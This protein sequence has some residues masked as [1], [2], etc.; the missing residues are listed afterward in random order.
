MMK[1]KFKNFVR[2][3]F[4]YLYFRLVRLLDLL[5]NSY[6]P[7]YPLNDIRTL[8]LV[9]VQ[10]IGDTVIASPCIRQIRRCFPEALLHMLVQNKSLDMVQYNPSL[11]K[12]FGVNHIT[13]YIQLCRVSLAFRRKQY[14]LVISLSPS[15]RNNLI[16]VLSGGKVISGYLNDSY[17]LPTNHHDHPIEVRGIHPSQKVIYYK[18]EPLRL[19]ALKAAA[20]FGVDLTDY[21]DTELFLPEE[22]RQFADQFL[23]RDHFQPN[24]LLIGLHPVCLNYFR[25][26]PPEKFAELGDSLVEYSM[27]IKIILIGTK[28]DEE[29]LRLIVSLMKHRDHVIWDTTLSILQ[30]ASI[31]KRCDVL[32][33]MD[34]CPSDISGALKIPTVHLHGPT[35]P[36]V[37]GPG[38]AKNFAVTQG[39]PCSPC[40]LNIHF[41]PYDK[42][43]M[44]GLEVSKVLDAT[45]RVIETY[46]PT[47]IHHA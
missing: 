2:T 20:P 16:A 29:T 35:D 21:V 32:I 28:E 39:I 13:S 33:G 8:L 23:R 44:N 15:V 34:S 30:T 9:E 24:D 6:K 27:D 4:R 41:C 43:C 46:R 19:R 36:K 40:G 18:E 1:D 26:W 11:D 22:S 47:K 7:P 12:A 17:F 37:T 25:N 14:D 45:L 31:I 38:G 5:L 10:D 3:L 42:R